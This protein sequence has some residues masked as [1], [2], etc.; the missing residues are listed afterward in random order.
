MAAQLLQFNIPCNIGNWNCPYTPANHVSLGLLKMT[1]GDWTKDGQ[2]T[3]VI[4]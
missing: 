1:L 3:T 2:T 4:Q